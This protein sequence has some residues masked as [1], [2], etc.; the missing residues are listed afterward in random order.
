MSTSTKNVVICLYL[1]MYWI[2]YRTIFEEVCLSYFTLILEPVVSQWNVTANTSLF[3]YGN[4][5]P[6]LVT[7]NGHQPTTQY[8]L[9]LHMLNV[10]IKGAELLCQGT[11]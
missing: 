8:D 11:L 5:C 1:I 3:K 7:L 9:T 2:D 6:S 10:L 4:I